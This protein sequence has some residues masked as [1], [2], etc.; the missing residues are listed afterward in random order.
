MIHEYQLNRIKAAEENIAKASAAR[1]AKFNKISELILNNDQAAMWNY[2]NQLDSA[3]GKA[4][5]AI[6]ENIRDIR[7]EH[8]LYSG[9]KKADGTF[10]STEER[11][12]NVQRVQQM[13]VGLHRALTKLQNDLNVKEKAYEDNLN[14]I[15]AGINALE[16]ATGSAFNRVAFQQFWNRLSNIQGDLLEELGTA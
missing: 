10:A 4:I 7:A 5:N 1:S 3:M 9:G 6:F 12:A 2:E 11:K 15:L 13:L 16:N 14:Q 8:N